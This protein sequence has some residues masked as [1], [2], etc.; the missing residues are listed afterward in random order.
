MLKTTIIVAALAVATPAL[1]Q[2]SQGAGSSNAAPQITNPTEKK[3]VPK[4]NTGAM[5]N[6]R[7]AES[8]GMTTGA[9][10]SKAGTSTSK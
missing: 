1:A 2:N 3:S 5:S 9:S 7:P 6:D 4:S 10:G 8:Q